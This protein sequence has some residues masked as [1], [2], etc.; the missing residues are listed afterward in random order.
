MRASFLVGACRRNRRF[1]GL[2]LSQIIATRE[3]PCEAAGNDH[4]LASPV[5]RRPE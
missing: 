4:P 5:V 2:M 3:V 1:C